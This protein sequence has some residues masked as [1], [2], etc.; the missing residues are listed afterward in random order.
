MTEAQYLTELCSRHTKISTMAIETGLSHQ[1]MMASLVRYGVKR[2]RAYDF[3]YDGVVDSFR[4][5]CRRYGINP[6]PAE[7][8]GYKYK[9]T[10][11]QALTMAMIEQ[12]DIIA[13]FDYCGAVDNLAGH[14]KRYGLKLAGVIKVKDNFGITTY[15][16][17]DLAI[18]DKS[19]PVRG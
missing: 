6:A 1:S 18:L 5:H 11:H 7:M 14:C 3:D 4:G 8:M 9:L 17:L 16:A 13:P 12:S 2:Q 19:W 15:Q 10:R